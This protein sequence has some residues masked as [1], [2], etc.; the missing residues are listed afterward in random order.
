MSSAAPPRARGGAILALAAAI[1]VGSVAFT[2]IKVVLRSVSPLTL[3]AGRVVF[4]AAA[5]AA[6]VA[7]QPRRRRPIAAGDRWRV[8][9]CG[10]GGSA[11]FHLLFSWGQDRVSVT[12][13]A[14]VLATMP[15]LVAAG[16]VAFLR[17]RLGAVQLAGLGLSLGG[18]AVTSWGGGDGGATSVLGALA[19]AG[20][21]AV[22]SA[23]TVVTRSVAARY[24]PWWLNTPGTMLGAAVMVALAAP[25]YRELGRLPALG[26]LELAWLGAVS[27]AFI[28]AALARAMRDFSATTTASLSTLVTPASVVVAWIGLREHTGPVAILGAVTVI[29]GVLLVTR[30]APGRVGRR[31][32]RVGRRAGRAGRAG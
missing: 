1:A 25:R 19:V 5:F 17:H 30:S 28:Y 3:A 16:E 9:F 2:L 15:A 11:G 32:G 21:T 20:A 31:A 18:V 4:S 23:V 26:W 12:V 27:S 14:V 24:D 7:L 6:V 22:W 8:L 10:L 29:G 13:A